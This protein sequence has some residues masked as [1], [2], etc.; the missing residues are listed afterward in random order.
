[1]FFVAQN[2]S[3]N[4]E[5]D[6]EHRN[7]ILDQR[8]GAKS[9]F[10]GGRVLFAIRKPGVRTPEYSEPTGAW[11]WNGNRKVCL[12]VLHQRS[13]LTVAHDALRWKLHIATPNSD[14][15]RHSFSSPG[16]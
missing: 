8:E 2:Q 15:F 3:P 4:Q 13:I 14:I 6:S 7:R 1:M 16:C 9:A 11:N 12:K 10:E 5:S